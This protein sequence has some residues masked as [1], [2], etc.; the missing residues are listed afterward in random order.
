M[1]K[2]ER[3]KQHREQLREMQAWWEIV[4]SEKNQTGNYTM[5]ASE[6]N[7][8]SGMRTHMQDVMVSL[9]SLIEQAQQ[10]MNYWVEPDPEVAVKTAASE[11]ALRRERRSIGPTS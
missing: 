9:N 10:S 6:R 2:I 1:K 5:P 4:F 7:N 11:G 8:L 3:F